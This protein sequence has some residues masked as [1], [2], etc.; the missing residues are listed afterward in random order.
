MKFYNFSEQDKLDIAFNRCFI[1]AKQ[2]NV[3][4]SLQRLNELS[5]VFP[6]D[7]QL[8]YAEA[9]IRKDF[10]GQGL[11]AF[12][13][14]KKAFE[15]DNNHNFAVCNA[16]KFSPSRE[17]FEKLS[18]KALIIAQDDIGLRNMI[19]FYKSYANKPYYKFLINLAPPQDSEEFGSRAAIFESILNNC[20]N[21]VNPQLKIKYQRNR[22]E[23][24]RALDR[25]AE[26]YLK[27]IGMQFFPEDRLA[28][29]EALSVLDNFMDD[30]NNP[31]FYDEELLNLRAAWT[32]LIKF[33]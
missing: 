3:N 33:R 25:K 17:E 8:A 10:L 29:K 18:K 22:A 31:A 11:K 26:N 21:E 5:Q 4:R 24:L 2:G 30:K 28:L 6:E 20:P 15:L 19:N 13:L 23:N 16:T 12:E 1:E 32:Y 9:L 27:H 7:S 14:F